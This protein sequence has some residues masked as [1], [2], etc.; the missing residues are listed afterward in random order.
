MTDAKDV[1]VQPILSSVRVVDFS[2]GW[3][4]PVLTQ[5][6]A[7][8]GA[9]VVKIESCTHTDWWRTS[10]AL[11]T[12]GPEDLDHPWEQSPLFNAVNENK[13]GVTLD[14]NQAKGVAVASALIARADIVVENFTPRVMSNLGLDYGTLSA[15]HPELIMVSMPAFG[16]TGPWADFK[17]TAFITESLAGV[18]S[19]CGYEDADPML[20]S[21]SF[22]D[23]N[24][25]IVG[26]L[27]VLMALRH[28]RLTGEGQHV[29]VAQTEALTPHLGGELL[30]VVM[31][32]AVP[33][34]YGNRRPESALCGVYPVRGDDRWIAIDVRDDVQWNA[35]ADELG[36]IDFQRWRTPEARFAD[37]FSID[38]V[39]RNWTV[40]WDGYEL[41]RRLQSIGVPAG[42][43][44]NA[45]DL[46]VDRH[47]GA[48]D[49]YHVME[50]KYVGAMPYPG[51]AV[52]LSRTPAIRKMPAPL[53]GEHNHF[54]LGNLLGMSDGAIAELE[55]EGVI[56]TE[57]RFARPGE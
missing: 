9:E 16:A 15:D 39:I 42:R 14:L 28:R 5:M 19:R 8:H 33:A 48:V 3:A 36:V 4:G 2:M 26:A 23:P 44:Q 47:L 50:R 6:L 1:A 35:L 27:S 29:E 49:F 54:V 11:F 24:A 32:G 43:V 18:S 55:Q 46:L 57:P 51:P 41:E 52:R 20:V 22:A 34:R 45:A 10:R 38:E 53:L 12:E 31:N 25:G 7:D 30:D 37:R 56:G 40:D 13:L 17:A 21:T